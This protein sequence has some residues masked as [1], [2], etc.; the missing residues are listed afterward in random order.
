MRGKH[1]NTTQRAHSLHTL[2]AGTYSMKGTEGGNTERE[3]S[4][5]RHSLGEG[6]AGGEGGRGKAKKGGR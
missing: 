2:L 4:V 5:E 3:N 1:H 6:S